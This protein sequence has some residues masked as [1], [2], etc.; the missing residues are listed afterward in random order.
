MAVG[1]F[2]HHA[3]SRGAL[4]ETFHDEEWLIHLLYGACIFANRSGDGGYAHWSAAELVDDGQQYAVVNLVKSVLI[5]VQCRQGYLSDAGI[6]LACT[7]NLG[8]ITHS[9]QQGIGDTGRPARPARYFCCRIVGNRYTQD[10]GRALN[11][12]L[13]CS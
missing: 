8:K 7:L 2:G 9:A 3:S 5:N 13:E 4:D 12:A 6:N 1:Q 10:T 11:D